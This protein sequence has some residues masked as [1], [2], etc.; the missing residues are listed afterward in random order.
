MT[1]PLY[2][3]PTNRDEG[4]RGSSSLD[5]R[6]IF[7]TSLVISSPGVGTGALMAITKAW[8]FSALGNLT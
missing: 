3:N 1:S 7:N 5:H 6:F 2:Q 8:Q 4:E